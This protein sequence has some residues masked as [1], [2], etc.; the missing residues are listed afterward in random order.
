M[1]S[2]A[3]SY[4]ASPLDSQ[5]PTNLFLPESSG[6]NE[7]MHAGVITGPQAVLVI[8]PAHYLITIV[9]ARGLIRKLYTKGL[10]RAGSENQWV[11]MRESS[12][13]MFCWFFKS[14]M[15]YHTPVWNQRREK[16][17]TTVNFLANYQDTSLLRAQKGWKVDRRNRTS[18][19]PW[20]MEDYKWTS[21]ESGGSLLQR[22]PLLN[23]RL[24]EAWALLLLAEP[25]EENW[26]KNAG[27]S[28]K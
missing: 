9:T 1:F 8:T 5:L 12:F 24:N 15:L 27:C 28:W 2:R 4:W 17:K 26:S 6:W 18:V 3:V 25:Q 10:P 7:K 20:K 21:E 23:V 13:F 19:H 14:L 16:K 22:P 11:I